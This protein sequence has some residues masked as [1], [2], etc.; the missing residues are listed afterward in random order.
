MKIALIFFSFLFYSF[1]GYG[2]NFDLKGIK[3]KYRKGECISFIIS[4]NDT[5]KLYLSSFVLEKFNK[6]DGEWSEQV[7]DILNSD[8]SEFKGKEGFVLQSKSLKR[9]IWNPKNV[10]PNCFSYKY[11]IG[12]YRLSF[13]YSIGLNSKEKYYLKE[14]FIVN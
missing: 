11:N 10:N 13:K 12:E 9:I 3:S 8:C 14:F 1:A 4:N 7:Y 2:Q 6:V 5:S